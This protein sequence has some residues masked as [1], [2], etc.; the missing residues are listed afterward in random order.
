MSRGK[1]SA[2]APKAAATA[3]AAEPLGRSRKLRDRS[4]IAQ[5]SYVEG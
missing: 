3:A 4:T 1:K 5:P 2:A